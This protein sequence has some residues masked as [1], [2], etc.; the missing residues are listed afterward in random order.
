MLNQQT[1]EKLY[2]MRMRGMADAFTQQQDDP[3]STQLSFEERFALLV[4][5][6]W[7]WRQNRALERRLR[8]GRLQVKKKRT[9]RSYLRPSAASQPP[10]GDELAVAEDEILEDEVATGADIAEAAVGVAPQEAPMPRAAP[11]ERHDAFAPPE[12][13]VRPASTVAS[14]RATAPTTNSRFALAICV[15]SGNSLSSRSAARRS[16]DT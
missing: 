11:V 12:T 7:N 14:T 10:N 5:R 9:D 3:Q 8:D 13:P 4:D 2:T 16:A 15:I 6:Q 1:I